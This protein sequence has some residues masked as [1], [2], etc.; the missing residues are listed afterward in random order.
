MYLFIFQFNFSSIELKLYFYFT[1]FEKAGGKATSGKAVG[2]VKGSTLP[3]GNNDFLYTESKR[4]RLEREKVP[5]P[6]IH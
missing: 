3:R 6:S 2:V 4:S 5:L 1:D